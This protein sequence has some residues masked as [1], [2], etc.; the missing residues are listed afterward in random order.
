MSDT[1]TQPTAPMDSA[2][3][4]NES[5]LGRMGIRAALVLLIIGST[6]LISCAE[7]VAAVMA[8]D[9]PAIN[10]TMKSLAFGA[11]CYYFGQKTTPA[12]PPVK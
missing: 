11:M 10:E 7:V 12:N 2:D 5:T 1:P 4:A 3:S 6:C 9:M 8:G